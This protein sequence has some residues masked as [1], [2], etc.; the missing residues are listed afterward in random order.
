MRLAPGGR[1]IVNVPN[2]ASWQSR[3]AGAKW[4]HLDVPRH[5][6]HFSPGSLATAFAA[7]GLKLCRL[8]YASFEHDPY[9]WVESALNRITGRPNTLTR[10]LMGMQPFGARVAI[11][12]V[13]GAILTPL[14]FALSVLSWAFRRGALLEATASLHSEKT[15]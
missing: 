14:A 5:L 10:F 8:G 6:V 2:F 11:S 9:G 1:V 4:L 7:A 15:R 13:A 12:M 3:F